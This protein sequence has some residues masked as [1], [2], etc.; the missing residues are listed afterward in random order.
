MRHDSESLFMDMS[1]EWKI[2]K[3]LGTDSEI[4]HILTVW[5]FLLLLPCAKAGATG[6]TENHGLSVLFF[7]FPVSDRFPAQNNR[8][9][10]PQLGQTEEPEQQQLQYTEQPH[11]DPPTPGNTA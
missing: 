1:P 9:G 10:L 7:F 5:P 11:G 6:I 3:K 8:A 2:S 4:H